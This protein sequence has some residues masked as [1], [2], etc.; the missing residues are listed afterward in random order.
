MTYNYKG[1]EIRKIT[2]K[3]FCVY[4]DNGKMIFDG[5]TL[6]SAKDYVDSIR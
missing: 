6:R 4:N 1:Y 2:R 3:D 5:L